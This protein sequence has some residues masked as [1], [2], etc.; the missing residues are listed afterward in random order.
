MANRFN[1]RQNRGA[2]ETSYRQRNTSDI[3]GQRMDHSLNSQNWVPYILNL[4]KNSPTLFGDCYEVIKYEK[5]LIYTYPM[6][7]EPVDKASANAKELGDQE[8]YRQ[9]LKIVME[10]S[11]KHDI[12]CNR[13]A[14]V[15]MS[16]S[17]MNDEYDL[18]L[19]NT[20]YFHMYYQTWNLTQ[21][22]AIFTV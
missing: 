10:L 14:D 3:H 11:A 12:A 5:K 20:H 1:P 13:V 17:Y 18:G 7:P 4:R 9:Q 19:K 2:S 21:N 6:A 8:I 15:L 22:Y 16:P